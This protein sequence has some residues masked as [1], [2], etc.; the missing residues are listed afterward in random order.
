MRTEDVIKDK[1]Q[2]LTDLEDE[3]SNNN[4][5]LQACIDTLSWVTGE[6][7]TDE[8]EDITAEFCEEDDDEDDDE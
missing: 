7:S 5:S 6:L 2:E 3:Q 8:Y 4:V 1:L